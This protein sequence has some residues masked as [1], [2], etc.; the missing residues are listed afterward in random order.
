MIHPRCNDNKLL[1]KNDSNKVEKCTCREKKTEKEIEEEKKKKKE[2]KSEQSGN[3]TEV[4]LC[5]DITTEEESRRLEF[6][7]FLVL[8]SLAVIVLFSMHSNYR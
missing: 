8:L 7:F 1:C 2:K 4:H 6:I 3:V 5:R